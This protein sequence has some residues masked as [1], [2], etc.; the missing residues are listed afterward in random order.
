MLLVGLSALGVDSALVPLFGVAATVV[1]AAAA[2]VVTVDCDAV[3]GTVVVS[4][5][6]GGGFGVDVGNKNIL[7]SL[8]SVPHVQPASPQR[9]KQFCSTEL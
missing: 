3:I 2:V 5:A 6:A 8:R 7:Q 4:G 9:S 1:V